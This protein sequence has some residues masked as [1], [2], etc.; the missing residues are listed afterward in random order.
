MAAKPYLTIVSAVDRACGLSLSEFRERISAL[1]KT[2]LEHASAVDLVVVCNGRP[3]YSDS[4]IRATL[5]AIPDVQV[6]V[7]A[8][9]V[10]RDVAFV[11]GIEAAVGDAVLTLELAEHDLAA[12]GPMVAALRSGDDV[13]LLEARGERSPDLY[14]GFRRAFLSAYGWM[15]G[16]DERDVL[17]QKL[18]SRLVVAYVLRHGDGATLLRSL[19]VAS[20]FRTRLL[21]AAAIDHPRRSFS[22]AVAKAVV[23][24]TSGTARP[25]RLVSGMA[26]LGAGAALIYAL[27]TIGVLLFKDDVAPGWPTLSL[28][29][30]GMFFV[31][32][33]IM[34]LLSEYV[35]QIH[36]RVVHR[37]SFFVAAEHRSQTMT[38]EQR[39]NVMGLLPESGFSSTVPVKVASSEAPVAPK[40]P[41]SSKSSST[42]GSGA[43]AKRASTRGRKKSGGEPV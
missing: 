27:W 12:I 25:L 3:P 18:L 32:S 33:S 23:L 30:S 37:P 29:V 7:L 35:V 41:R 24:M 17:S 21:P 38:R 28:L 31:T 9:E 1:R 19:A 5:D 4:E 36:S 34:A 15:T 43:V 11:A 22:S 42:V 14:D 20:G 26:A 39:L 40:V 8:D 16:I 10:D 13:V 2:A 6:F